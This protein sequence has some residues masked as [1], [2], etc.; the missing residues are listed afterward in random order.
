MHYLYGRPRPFA[1]LK[2]GDM[3]GAA[4]TS[5]NKRRRHASIASPVARSMT[6]Y[7]LSVIG[8]ALSF[9]GTAIRNNPFSREVVHGAK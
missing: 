2:Q 1:N 3:Q 8:R 5:Q 9:S 7:C 6:I 4:P